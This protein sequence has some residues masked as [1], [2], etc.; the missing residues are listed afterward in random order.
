MSQKLISRSADLKRLRD[1]GV[2]I[3]VRD[4]F[5]L[6]HS[7]PYVDSDRKI[8]YGILVSE[9]TL[10]GDATSKPETHVINFAGEYPCNKDGSPIKQIAHSS[11]RKTLKEGVDIDHSFSSKPRPEGYIDYYEKI[12]TYIAIISSPA[13]ALDG[14]VS[15]KGFSVVESTEDE[16][17]FNY[18][19]TNSSRAEILNITS[20]LEGQKLAIIGLG[21]TGSYVL[22]L[23]AKTPVQE[24]HL[25]D[26][27]RF[28][29]HNAFRAPGAP[30]KQILSEKKNKAQYFAEI[31]SP[32]RRNIY[33]H[34]TFVTSENVAELSEVGFVFICIDKGSPKEAILAK[35]VE[36][37]IP[38]V[39]VGM[40][41]EAVDDGLIGQIRITAS[42]KD[43]RDH[44]DR[45]IPLAEPT[46]GDYASNIQIAEL[47]ALNASLAVIKWKKLCGFYQD[48]TG[49]HNSIYVINTGQLIN[50]DEA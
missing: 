36:C 10:A 30:S 32:M 35:L 41:V 13:K 23:V 8:K 18:Y 47:N 46:D 7:V 34:A 42:T 45:R 4:G 44:I 2:Q 19:D 9:L 3:E 40:G 12:T 15:E 39:D 50:E 20:R 14:T 1:E 6:V 43:A 24:I 11:G 22:D 25:F 21:G 26:G 33:P 37:G 48:L 49:E 29:Q 31:Y 38:F 28:L 27:D 16:S 5:L 17:V